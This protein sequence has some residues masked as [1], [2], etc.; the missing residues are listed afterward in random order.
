MSGRMLYQAAGR[1]SGLKLN[2]MVS[3]MVASLAVRR[4]EAPLCIGPP[5]GA[6]ASRSTQE[7]V[8]VH[9]GGLDELVDSALLGRLV[10]PPP[11]EP[12]PVTGPAPG[13]TGSSWPGPEGAGRSYRPDGV[14]AARPGLGGPPW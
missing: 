1:S 6:G 8:Q 5:K 9:L 10:R 12:G 4:L 2:W 7:P 11:K 13:P 14:P 3:A